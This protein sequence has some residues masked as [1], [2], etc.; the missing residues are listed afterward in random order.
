MCMLSVHVE[1]ARGHGQ[2]ISGQYPGEGPMGRREG[3]TRAGYQFN[4]AVN[5]CVTMCRH[6]VHILYV[7]GNREDLKLCAIFDDPQLYNYFAA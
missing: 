6:S 1:W 2:P 4:S 7:R 3:C 5:S